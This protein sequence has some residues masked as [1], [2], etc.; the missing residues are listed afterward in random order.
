MRR[1]RNTA[2]TLCLI[3]TVVAA[4]ATAHAQVPKQPDQQVSIVA[5]A[6]CCEGCAQ[7]VTS[8]LYAAR[9]VKTVDVVIETRTVTVTLPERG[10]ASLGHLWDAVQ[11]GEGGPTQLS[12]AEATYTFAAAS[13]EAPTH[14]AKTKTFL[15]IDNLHCMGCAQKLARQIYAAKGVKKVSVDL[16][17]DTLIIETG[18]DSLIS[19]WL[20]ID[21]A[22]KADERPL[23]VTGYYGKIAIEWATE[24]TPKTDHHHAQQP[25]SGDIQR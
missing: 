5:S 17:K 8:N 20:V 2:H 12:T 25:A 14:V 23:S 10:G 7:K 9:G 21:A 15:V 4:T 3:L 16:A 13:T 18:P 24:R 19:P 22:A 11:Q 6:M 1:K